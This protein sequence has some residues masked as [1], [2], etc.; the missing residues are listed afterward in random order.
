MKRTYVV[1]I[2][3]VHVSYVEVEVEEN[4][5]E[6]TIKRRAQEQ[7]EVMDVLSTEWS[8]N[9]DEDLWSVEETS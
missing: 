1:G 4:T 9:L 5:P 2:R 7:L 3:E 8:H 6:H